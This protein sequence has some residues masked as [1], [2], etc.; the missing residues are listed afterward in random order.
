MPTPEELK[1]PF[2]P[3]SFYHVVCK[4]IDGLLLFY[5]A[6]DYE[7]FFHRFKKFTGD[8]LY[9]W[10]YCLLNNHTHHVV[11]IKSADMIEGFITQLPAENKSK[12]MIKWVDALG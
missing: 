7:V 11:K 6:K 5:D 1:A 8:F 10:S 12:A 4:S 3:D 9:V 2:H